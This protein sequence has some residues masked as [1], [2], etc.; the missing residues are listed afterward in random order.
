MLICGNLNI[1]VK[2]L[3]T[4]SL[5]PPNIQSLIEGTHPFIKRDL[6]RSCSFKKKKK[7]EKEVCHP[8]H[9]WKAARFL[10]LSR[11]GEGVEVKATLTCSK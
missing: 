11:V 10:E 1:S 2:G 7:G 5:Q 6:E 9:S 3:E 8:S 4:K